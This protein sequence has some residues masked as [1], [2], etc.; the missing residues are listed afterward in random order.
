MKCCGCSCKSLRI[1]MLRRLAFSWG[2]FFKCLFRHFCMPLSFALCV[3]AWV[4]GQ[5]LNSKADRDVRSTDYLVASPNDGA[6]TTWVDRLY[7]AMS[8]QQRIGQLLMIRA[9]SDRG[10]DHERQVCQAVERYQVGGLCFFQGTA[11]RQAELTNEFQRH[12]PQVPLL[13]AM[14]AEWGL[15]MRLASDTL[16][17]PRALTLGS[18][19]GDELIYRMGRDIG[20]QCRRLGVHVN[21]APVL[22][23]NINP[24]NPV[25][26]DR[27][28]GEDPL[29]VASKASAY[30]RG[31]QDERV[32]ACGK[33][34][35]GHGDTDVDSH[36]ELP[37]IRHDRRRLD[38]VEM[39]PFR[40]LIDRGLGSIMV[41][42]LNVPSLDDTPNRPTTLSRKVVD[43]ILRSDLKFSGLIFTDALEMKG[44]T[45]F[46]SSGM[47]E[48]EA[49]KAGN[50]VLLLPENVQA[51]I[52]ALSGAIQAGFISD[53][54]LENSVKRI[55]RIK[56]RLGLHE[57]AHVPV[58]GMSEDLNRPESLALRRDLLKEAL[59][60]VRDDG[61]QRASLRGWSKANYPTLDSN[62]PLIATLAIGI[63]QPAGQAL[64]VFQRTLSTFQAV[65]HFSLPKEATVEKWQELESQLAN[66]KIV[67]V[68]FHDLNRSAKANFGISKA[69]I[70]NVQRIAK[71]RPVVAVHFG[72]PYGL[73][74]YDGLPTVVQAN[75][76]SDLAQQLAA[77][78]LFGAIPF[79]GKLPITASPE[80]QYGAG[81]Q[82]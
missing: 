53:Q 50:D 49:F 11:N 16:S 4:T 44:V 77:Q 5:V 26:N 23:V 65:A 75:E 12:S 62:S 36:Y 48:V 42:H 61:N 3:Q 32:L 70:K 13:I 9:H 30:V 60:L 10:E 81:L 39:S 79:R 8:L 46:F 80:A 76:E 34:F 18:M 31:L 15:G 6:E 69:D 22:D 68:S 35:P 19:T 43:G 73:K 2:A 40:S 17:Y 78:A 33:H 63:Q 67:I 52:E 72:N 54:R 51:S 37:V 58:E 1:V 38:T 7:E 74:H 28:F 55:L 57:G 27:S 20:R 82:P 25:I 21:F 24:N 47:A 14:D 41:A 59:V 64:T 56:Y 66:A 71:S 45:K 29:N